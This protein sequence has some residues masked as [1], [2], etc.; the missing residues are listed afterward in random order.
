[1]TK[2]RLRFAQYGSGL[3]NKRLRFDQ[4]RLR[5]AQNGSSLTNERFRF[6]Q[7][8]QVECPTLRFSCSIVVE[9]PKRLTAAV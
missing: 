5:F 6:D 9:A 1:M 4:E 3:T 2:K 7:I 8:A